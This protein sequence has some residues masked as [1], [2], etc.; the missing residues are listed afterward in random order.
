MDRQENNIPRYVL[1]SEPFYIYA[2]PKYIEDVLYK[3]ANYYQIPKA[4]VNQPDMVLNGE[5]GLNMISKVV[6][7]CDQ[8]AGSYTD[9]EHG[10]KVPVG[11]AILMEYAKK[12][13]EEDI[14]DCINSIGYEYLP[15]TFLLSYWKQMDPNRVLTDMQPK[16]EVAKTIGLIEN[17]NM[18]W[19]DA[20]LKHK[21]AVKINITNTALYGDR[22][23]DIVNKDYT[24]VKR[25]PESQQTEQL[26]KLALEHNSSMFLTM[27]VKFKTKDVEDVA[28]KNAI[29]IKWVRDPALLT[30]Y[31]KRALSINPNNLQYLSVGA[32][33]VNDTIA[34]NPE[35]A[36]PM[37]TEQIKMLLP[38][39]WV[40]ALKAT[41]DQTG[42]NGELYARLRI[43]AMSLPQEIKAE[44]FQALVKERVYTALEC[45][46]LLPGNKLE[47]ECG[48]NDEVVKCYT[49]DLYSSKE[50]VPIILRH[51]HTPELAV[52]NGKRWELT[53][54]IW[55]YLTKNPDKIATTLKEYPTLIKDIGTNLLDKLP[56]TEVE[57]ILEEDPHNIKYFEGR[58]LSRISKESLLKALIV[59]Y[60]TITRLPEAVLT[61]SLLELLLKEQ[62]QAVNFISAELL[63]GLDKKA[64]GKWVKGSKQQS[65]GLE[66]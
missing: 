50:L 37:T 63:Q 14:T 60:K 28:L 55:D 66:F 40:K 25:L 1:S 48:K 12:L 26:W 31:T 5:Y 27:P 4:L 57:R 39:N 7:L 19:I 21:L 34:A 10:G 58:T 32:N 56:N 23:N 2:S 45:V 35:S 62:P 43:T 15:M 3:Y 52:P 49:R 8:Y 65:T 20:I 53:A 6:R 42:I 36:V 29:W 54:C 18:E 47:Y 41:K 51:I 61:K 30:T 9:P 11:H 13:K 46:R 59:D 44:I 38:E 33:E 24:V 17:P 16:T 64:F 22:L